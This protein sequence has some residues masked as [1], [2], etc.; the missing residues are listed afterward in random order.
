MAQ[1]EAVCTT[2]QGTTILTTIIT[3]MAPMRLLM[4]PITRIRIATTKVVTAIPMHRTKTPT[5]VTMV[6]TTPM[7]TTPMLMIPM[8]MIPMRTTPMPMIPMR[9]PQ[10]EAEN[11]VMNG[12][13]ILT[14]NQDVITTTI[15]SQA[16]HNGFDEELQPLFFVIVFFFNNDVPF[17]CWKEGTND[18]GGSFTLNGYCS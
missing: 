13:S 11:G 12:P 18:S 10:T 17:M 1:M 3:H 7:R 4:T 16:K 14:K 9:T 2:T 8:L 6:A 5:P 15:V